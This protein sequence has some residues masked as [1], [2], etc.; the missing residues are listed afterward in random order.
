V[1]ITELFEIGGA[2][3]PLRRQTNRIGHD[4]LHGVGHWYTDYIQPNGLYT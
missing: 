1:R 2:F 3:A 4:A